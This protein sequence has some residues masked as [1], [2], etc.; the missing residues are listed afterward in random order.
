MA[1]IRE[2]VS[3]AAPD[4][5]NPVSAAIATATAEVATSECGNE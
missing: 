2:S 4:N 5:N 1:I 3:V